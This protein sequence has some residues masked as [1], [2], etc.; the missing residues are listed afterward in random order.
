[1]NN[2]KLGEYLIKK[3]KRVYGVDETV[4][5]NNLTHFY[6]CN[7]NENLPALNYNELDYVILLDVIEH[8]HDPEDFMQKLYEKLSENE[9]VEI[10]ISTP[11]IS[12]LL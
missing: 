4:K 9:K 11:N 6:E 1:M 3:K 8:L 12:F 7:L 10:I 5:N 2:G